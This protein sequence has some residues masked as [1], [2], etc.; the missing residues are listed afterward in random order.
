M[1]A[2]EFLIEKAPN[3]QVVVP[4]DPNSDPLYSLKAA[5][6]HKIKDLP[7]TPEV[8]NELKEIEDALSHLDTGKKKRGS[9]EDELGTWQ[10]QDVQEAKSMLARYIVSMNAPVE[11]RRKMLEIWKDKG[12][13]NLKQLLSTGQNTV[14]NIVTGY[15]KNPAIKEMADDLIMIDSQGVGKGEFMLRVLSPLITKSVG[16]GDVVVKNKGTLEIKTNNQ[17]PARFHDRTVKPASGWDKACVDFRTKYGQYNVTGG[18]QQPEQAQQ[19]APKKTIK[20]PVVPAANTAP[21][22]PQPTATAPATQINQNPEAMQG[23][24]LAE[25]KQQDGYSASGINLENLIDLYTKVPAELKND[26]KNELTSIIQ[27]IF[28]KKADYAKP[29]VDSLISGNVGKTKQLYAQAGLFNYIEYKDDIGILFIDIAKP[30]I[31]F[32][33]FN[34]FKTLVSSGLRLNASTAYPI[35]TGPENAYPATKVVSTKQEQPTL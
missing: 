9:A 23:S 35:S 32:T 33:F 8:K 10:D 30:P 27:M 13:I 29:I 19:A 1:R 25:A 31:T 3:Q 5:I 34:D 7:N 26:F 22:N 17:S 6:A 14:K 16:G 20:K 18:G 24:N 12:L 11:A 4:G 2:L 15:D 21:I 28:Q